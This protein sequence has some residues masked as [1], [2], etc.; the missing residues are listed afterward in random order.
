M[1]YGSQGF[2]SNLL[3]GMDVLLKLGPLGLPMRRIR[4]VRNN[5]DWLVFYKEVMGTPK[6]A[7]ARVGQLVWVE[8]YFERG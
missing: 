5:Y 3:K 2:P 1:F 8:L 6:N 7:R 4:K